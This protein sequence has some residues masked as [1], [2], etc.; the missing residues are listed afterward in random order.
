MLQVKLHDYTYLQ[1][2]HN[3]AFFR[4]RSHR[5]TPNHFKQSLG[6][7]MEWNP[8]LQFKFMVVLF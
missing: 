7:S 2:R 4:D 8:P 1:M 6:M 5:D 3:I